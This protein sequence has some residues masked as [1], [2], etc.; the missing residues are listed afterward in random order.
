MAV[1]FKWFRTESCQFVLPWS[2]L[3]KGRTCNKMPGI[4][5]YEKGCLLRSSIYIL[6]FFVKSELWVASSTS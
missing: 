3:C 4:F 2:L 6:S 1:L 5:S